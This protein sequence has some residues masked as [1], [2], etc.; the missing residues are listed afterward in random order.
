MA[1]EVKID[2]GGQRLFFEKVAWFT[3]HN[4]WKNQDI[5]NGP[6]VIAIQRFHFGGGKIILEKIAWF[7]KD[8][9]QKN[10]KDIYI[11]LLVWHQ[12]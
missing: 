9:Q 10:Y 12:T 1:Q 8:V 7:I 3:K 4:C 5:Y 11:S 2:L 6:R